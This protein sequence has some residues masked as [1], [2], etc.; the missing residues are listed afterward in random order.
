MKSLNNI[1]KKSQHRKLK[2]TRKR[3][4]NKTN[5]KVK[6]GGDPTIFAA[7]HEYKHR[8]NIGTLI[9]NLKNKSEGDINV[10]N[11]EKIKILFSQLI[12]RV[13]MY[14]NIY[15]YDLTFQD[16][17]ELYREHLY[18]D[19]NNLN[20]FFKFL[21]NVPMLILCLYSCSAANI[22]GSPPFFSFLFVLLLF[23]LRVFFNFL[24][25]DFL[26]ILFKLFIL[27]YI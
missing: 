7:E 14:R 17:N 20:L 19:Q 6:K 5:K 24:R 18:Y 21:I 26:S 16:H 1:I 13:F 25:C 12:T 11:L 22:V 27:K 9:K 3:N 4:N 8:I 2:N 10:G 15:T 23:L